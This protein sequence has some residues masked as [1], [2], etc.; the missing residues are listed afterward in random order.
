[1]SR[2]CFL[3][4]AVLL[5]LAA[6]SGLAAGCGNDKQDPPD[7]T[8]VGPALGTDG[9][10]YPKA[11][12]EFDAPRG[13][14]IDAGKAPL[15]VT[16]QTGRAAVGIWRYPRTE[17]LPKTK[18]ELLAARDALLGAARARDNGF[19]ELKTGLTEVDGAPAVQVRGVETIEGQQRTVRS[20]HVYTRGAEIVIDAIA[21]NPEF[22]R[23][24][25]IIF[26]PL[27]RTLKISAPK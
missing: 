18:A 5:S 8:T 12:I 7:V 22:R 19:R 15:V 17:P 4:A 21:P 27:L 11:G 9:V 1:M 6:L 2:R 25:A 20:T 14:N 16:V 24:D 26:R 10:S 3:P 13:W 23:V